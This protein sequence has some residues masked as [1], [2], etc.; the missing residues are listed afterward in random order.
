MTALTIFAGGGGK[1]YSE[2]PVSGSEWNASF[3]EKYGA[4]NVVWETQEANAKGSINLEQ[5]A[6][7]FQGALDEFA[8]TKRTTAAARVLNPDGTEQILI[9]SSANRLSP[10]QRQLLKIGEVEAIGPGH[11]EVTIINQAKANS[12]V[13]LDIAASRPICSDC[14]TAIMYVG[15]NPVSPLKVVR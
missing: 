15:A 2:T 8:Q 14:S 7:Q 3:C 1:A 9:G 6:Q 13:I 10:A 11:A 5:R 4:E 12:Q